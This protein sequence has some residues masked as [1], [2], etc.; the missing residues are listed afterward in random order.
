[1]KSIVAAVITCC[2][3][4]GA[5]Y[6]A[7]VYFAQA[8]AEPEDAATDPVEET[9]DVTKTLPPDEDPKKTN[10]P[11]QVSN[12]PDKSVSLE[13]VLQM[14]D[15]VR[16]MEEKLILRERIVAKEEQ[17]VQLMFTDLENERTRLQ[18]L[19]ERVTAEVSQLQDMTEKVNATLATLESRRAEVSN[20]EKSAG[21]DEESKQE[22]LE[23]KVNGVK[24]WF[25]NLEAQQASTYLKEFA[26]N[27][28]LEFA[29]SLLQK[30]P[31]RQKSKILGALS[32]PLL[33]EQ[34]IDALKVKQKPK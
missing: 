31:D 34:L 18:A 5:S 32:D 29:A 22:E 2:I 4:F 17:R 21:V 14:S 27:G 23:S 6:A 1:M 8:A 24:G 28:K 20:M 12:R 25:A 9:A 3:L 7:S 30:M 13:A 33:V 19:A 15:S 10:V 11:M 26:N 16:K